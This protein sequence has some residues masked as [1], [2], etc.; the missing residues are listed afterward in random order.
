MS[1]EL[2]DMQIELFREFVR[3][4]ICCSW[5]LFWIHILTTLGT[6]WRCLPP[7]VW[8][9]FDLEDGSTVAILDARLRVLCLSYL[10]ISTHSQ[11]EQTITYL[12][13]SSHYQKYPQSFNTSLFPLIGFLCMLYHFKRFPLTSAYC[14]WVYHI[15]PE[16][17]IPKSNF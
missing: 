3:W 10:H 16:I 2:Y 1:R 5:W 9:Y 14:L 6:P 12:I 4:S 11:K 8:S 7:T 15:I 17:K 13:R